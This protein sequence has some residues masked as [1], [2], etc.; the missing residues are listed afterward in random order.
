MILLRIYA[1]IYLYT[2]SLLL[3]VILLRFL[4]AI[5]LLFLIILLLISLPILHLYLLSFLL[6]YNIMM[7]WPQNLQ[8]ILEHSIR[9]FPGIVLE[10]GAD[11]L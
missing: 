8:T 9:N 2:C 1:F 5:G 11:D 10:Y 7:A 4:F 6:V 3:G